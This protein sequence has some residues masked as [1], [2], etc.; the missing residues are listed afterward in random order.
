MKKIVLT[1]G[2]I[3]GIGVEI[4]IKALNSLDCSVEDIVIAGSK[5]VFDLYAQNYDLKLN[6]DYE[7]A[8][9]KFDERSVSIGEENKYSA[10]HCFLCLQKACELVKSN[11]A[12]SIVTAPVSKHALNLG[13]YEFSGQTEILEKFLAHDVQK[14]EMLFVSKDFRVFLLTR[15]L[16][17]ENVPRVINSKVI[18]DKIKRLNNALVN[19]FAIAEPKIGVL[20]LNPHAGENGLLGEEEEQVIKPSIA[21]LKSQGLKVA[22][23]LVADAEFARFGRQYFSGEKFSYDCYVAMYHDQGLIPMKLLAQDSAV[24][25]TIGLDVI[26]TSPSHG[27][28]FDIA[29]LNIARED[30]MKAAINL[31]F[32]VSQL[33]CLLE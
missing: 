16:P 33:T 30:S 28:A 17:L 15:H 7:I 13:G 20:A 10:E 18:I 5:R 8:D 9:V 3:N 4:L 1:Y 21:K 19:N 23:P 12:K 27:T 2:D 24:N 6:K 31:A 22:G 25:V 26:R 32:D 14:S 11:Y 29:G